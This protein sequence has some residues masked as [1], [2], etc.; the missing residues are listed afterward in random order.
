[1][2]CAIHGPLNQEAVEYA[3]ILEGDFYVDPARL[4]RTPEIP[5]GGCS[6]VEI[7]SK[8]FGDPAGTRL[9]IIASRCG[10]GG[11]YVGSM[12]TLNG[13]PVY[14][15]MNGETSRVVFNEEDLR[16]SQPPITI[17][18]GSFKFIYADCEKGP[19]GKP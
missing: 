17:P 4:E 6:D 2:K 14:A 9:Q 7:R 18:E 10:P 8:V 11:V 1:M 19:A 15:H 3:D 16:S 12:V 13:L 5:G